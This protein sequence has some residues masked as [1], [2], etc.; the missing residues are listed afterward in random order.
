MGVNVSL[1]SVGTEAG[2]VIVNVDTASDVVVRWATG[3]D[4]VIGR[5]T[6]DTDITYIALRQADGT[7]YKVY[8]AAGEVTTTTA[9]L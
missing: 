6:A 2:D 3:A 4:V 8:V 9:A 1:P 5:G 7:Q